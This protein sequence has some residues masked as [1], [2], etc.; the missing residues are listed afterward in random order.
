MAGPT[1]F[2]ELL[3]KVR[4]ELVDNVTENG[5]NGNKTYSVV[6]FLTDGNCHDMERTKELLV[7]MT[8][9]PFSGVVV[10]VGDGNF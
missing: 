8:K 7:E 1:Y 2:G 5:L 4:G 10:G 9:L 6:I 3:E